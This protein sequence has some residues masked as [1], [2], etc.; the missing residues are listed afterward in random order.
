M[1]LDLETRFPRRRLAF[2]PSPIH[3]LTR[4]SEELGVEVWA[5]R[6]DIASGLAFGGNK[7]RKLEWLAADALAQ[8]C[9]AERLVLVDPVED[10][11]LHMRHWL[12]IRSAASLEIGPRITLSFLQSQLEAG[13]AVEAAGYEISPKLMHRIN[14][15]KLAPLLESANGTPVQ[16]LDIVAPRSEAP[17]AVNGRRVIAAEAPWHSAEPAEPSELAAALAD[18]VEAQG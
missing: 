7:I 10:G 17:P 5:K 11:R 14:T 8:G 12:R 2:W 4:L 1:V 9:R 3:P 6:D 13:Q 16:R 18:M 15:L